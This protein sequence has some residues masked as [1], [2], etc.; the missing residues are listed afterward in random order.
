MPTLTFFAMKPIFQVHLRYNNKTHQILKTYLIYAYIVKDKQIDI[1]VFP[2]KQN[3]TDFSSWSSSSHPMVFSG[4]GTL[5]P[6]PPLQKRL[7]TIGVCRPKV[8]P[9]VLPFSKNLFRHMTYPQDTIRNTTHQL[10][11]FPTHG[12]TVIV[13]V[14]F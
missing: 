4:V 12:Y 1:F 14:L 13:S 9:K 2:W 8:P 6:P 11:N 10:C 5:S 7:P 3:A